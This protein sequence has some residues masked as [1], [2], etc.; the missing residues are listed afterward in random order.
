MWRKKGV[1]VMQ[2]GRRWKEEVRK[3]IVDE[4]DGVDDEEIVKLEENE[5]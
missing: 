4:M 5:S 3:E 2:R 1:Q